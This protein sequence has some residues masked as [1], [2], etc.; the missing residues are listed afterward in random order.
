MTKY[1]PIGSV[2]QLHKGSTKVMIINRFPLYN[3]QGTIGYF[4]YSA[5]LYPAGNTD[6][7][8]YF[9]NHENIDKVWFE[10]Y[11]DEQEEAMQERFEKSQD[12]IPYPRLSLEG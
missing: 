7:Q 10:G 1:L 12:K 6:N 8:V 4:D 11:I 9:F 2:V 3:N 5:C